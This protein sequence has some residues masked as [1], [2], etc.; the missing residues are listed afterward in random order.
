MLVNTVAS[1]S[2]GDVVAVGRDLGGAGQQPAAERVEARA[3]QRGGPPAQ[4]RSQ[5]HVQVGRVPDQQ[6]AAA[7]RA[8]DPGRR[9]LGRVDR[10][11]V[12]LMVAFLSQRNSVTALPATSRL[13]LVFGGR[14]DD[15]D[16]QFGAPASSLRQ[17]RFGVAD[18]GDLLGVAGVV[19]G[20]V[21]HPAGTQPVGD[22]RRPSPAAAAGACG[23]GPWATDRGR[24]PAPRSASRARSGGR[25]T[26]TASPRIS[27]ILVTC[28]RSIAAEQLRQAAAIDLDGDHVDVR[29]GLRHRERGSSC[30]AADFK[31]KWSV[32]A[33][34][35][36]GIQRFA[37]AR[38]R[39][40]DGH[41]AELGP[42]PLPGPLLRG[43]QLRAPRTGS[44][45]SGGSRGTSRS[46]GRAVAGVGGVAASTQ[47][48]ARIRSSLP[49]NP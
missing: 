26:S 42:Q 20:G 36:A 44:W 1:G 11:S 43:R 35:G 19:G 3:F 15:R 18:L 45:W 23:A 10:S 2:A 31:D 47:G 37:G 12:R 17:Q 39:A 8:S 21:Q 29:L 28:S 25:S 49:M 4:D 6:H 22:Q 32:A 38:C 16:R 27:R 41:V 46:A 34:P 24:T 5:A 30:A 40:G 13:A 14:A 48:C 9:T 7:R 33:E